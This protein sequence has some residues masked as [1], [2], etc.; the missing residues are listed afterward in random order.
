MD[1][2]IGLTLAAILLAVAIW[3]HQERKPALTTYCSQPTD[4]DPTAIVCR[5]T[6]TGRAE[7]RDVRIG[8]NNMLPL[9]TQVIAPPDTGAR[10]EP[11]AM[12]P[13]P[14]QSPNAAR[15]QLAFSVVIPR[16]P[17]RTSVE[18]SLRTLNPD[19][20]RAGV[21]T[22]RLQGVMEQVLRR[23]GQCLET[24]YGGPPHGWDLELVMAG[25][26]KRQSFFLPGAIVYELGRY[27][28]RWITEA[29]ELAL[30]VHQDYYGRHKGDCVESF[31]T[32][33]P[34]KAPVVR[35]Q[36]SDGPSTY[37][38]FPPYLQTFVSGA[39]SLS[40]LKAKGRV[41]IMPPAPESYD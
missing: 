8:F 17:A 12:M 32:E 23:F 2:S 20:A 33:A 40:E 26:R 22:T 36:A 24:I 41:S 38:V 13:H 14:A 30:A 31:Q 4:G 7:S 27:P 9:D 34:F 11:A 29:E 25:H 15:L 35:I 3:R 28:V 10:I 37:V 5:I 16:I 39:M 21:Q 6:N 19:N 1:P 18:F